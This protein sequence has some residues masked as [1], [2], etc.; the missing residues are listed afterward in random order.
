MVADPARVRLTL[1]HDGRLSFDTDELIDSGGTLRVAVD[2][3]LVD[4]SDWR[5]FHK[6][7]LRDRYREARLRHPEADDVLL[8]N[9][10]GE[11]TE[12]TI[13]NVIVLLDGEWVTPPV[14]SGCLPGVLRRVLLEQGEIREM[15]VFLADL[16]RAD[17]LA[18]I[19]SVRMRVPAVLV[20]SV[21]PEVNG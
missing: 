4:P 6:T 13:A 12:S 20:V 5:L 8:V 1:H 3:V 11:I 19:N 16:A 17:G 10:D 2:H 9:L 14:A 21:D 15:P 18:L 7:S